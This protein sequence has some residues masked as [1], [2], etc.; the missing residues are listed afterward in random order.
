[1][2]VDLMFLAH[3]RAEFT[4]ASFETLLENTD[5]DLVHTAYIYDDRS[6]DGTF[7][8]L[9]EAFHRLPCHAVMTHST[10]GGP[11]AAMNHMLDRTQ[12][13]VF[14][15]IDNDLIVP[16]GWLNTMLTVFEENVQLDALGM[17][18]GFA[19]PVQ[20]D[21]TVRSFKFSSHIGG[22]GLFRTRAF[23]RRR[24]KPHMRW[25]GFTQHQRKHMNT[26]WV[27]PDIPAFNL[28]HLPLEPW[29]LLTSLYVQK[30]WS[31]AWPPYRPE[32]R[33]Y[34]DWWTQQQEAV[35]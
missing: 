7:E 8:Y 35:A 22:Q 18:P 12:Q 31:R 16:P 30:G 4:R 1:M 24:P 17:E 33:A 6:I 11:V 27:D 29:S 10:F 13:T 9:D 26:A 28:D 34:W 20:P 15:K 3:N 23:A 25:F 19:T 2:S 14:A 21:Y 5:W 32:M